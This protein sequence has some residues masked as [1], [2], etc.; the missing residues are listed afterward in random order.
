[1]FLLLLVVYLATLIYKNILC[2]KISI[3]ILPIA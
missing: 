3:Q 1:M 2:I